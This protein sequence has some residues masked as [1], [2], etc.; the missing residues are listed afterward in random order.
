MTVGRHNWT[1]AGSDDGG[2]RAAA[3]YTLIETGNLNDIDC[4]NQSLPEPFMS[5]TQRRAEAAA[6]N[7][8]ANG[9]Q[10]MTI[11]LR[12]NTRHHIAGFFPHRRSPH[13]CTSIRSST[14]LVIGGRHADCHRFAGAQYG[15]LGR[16]TYPQK[17]KPVAKVRRIPHWRSVNFSH[18]VA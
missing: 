13:M 8:M 18:R 12:R 4:L 15:K 5:L 3:V 11:A 1:F 10:H 7:A 14:P 6:I 16:F 2:R 9:S 17:S